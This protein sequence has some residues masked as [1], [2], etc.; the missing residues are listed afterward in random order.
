VYLKLLGGGLTEAADCCVFIGEDI[1]NSEELRD[2]QEIVHFLRQLQQLQVALP[3][4]HGC[5]AADELADSRT[6]NVIH[7]GEIQ[8]NHRAPI[9]QQSANR[10]SQESAALAQ[11]DAATQI[12]NSNVSGIA[13]RGM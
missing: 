11:N 2:L 4:F 8:Q 6:V 12:H 10:L 13:M 1:E 3:A 7:V 9:V 5:V